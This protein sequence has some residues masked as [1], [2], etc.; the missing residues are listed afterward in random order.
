MRYV[1]QAAAAMVALLFPLSFEAH[2]QGVQG[3]SITNYQFVSEQ[4]W[5]Q[6]QSYVTYRADLVNTGVARDAVTATVSSSSPSI[7]TVPGQT[8]LHFSPVPANSRVT[9][10][11]TFTIL[12]D[13]TVPF[14]FSSLQWSFLAPYANAGPNQTV[15]IGATVTVNG[16]AST[17]PSG[18]GNLSY[19]WAFV[20]RP[21]GTATKLLGSDA[22]IAQFTVDV[23]GNYVLSLTVSNGVG[24]DTAFVTISTTNSPPVANAG[25][26]QTVGLGATVT[27]NGGGSSDVDG[28][29]LTYSWTLISRPAGSVATLTG[30]NTV[31]PTFVVDKAGAYVAQLI[32][33]DGKVNSA[34]ATVQITTINTPPVANAGPNQIVNVGSTVQLNGSAS[35]DVDGDSLTYH[36]SFNSRPDGS[37]AALSNATAV[38]PTFTADAP[39]TY[40]VQL[41]VNDGK[42][43][44]NPATVTITT[45]ALQPPTANAGSNQTVQHGATV[46]LNGSAT[47][48]QGLPLKLQWS[49]ITKPSGSAAVLSSTTIARPTFVA[50]LPGTYIADRKSV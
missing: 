20:S 31:S 28:D 37:A 34:P 30:A 21:P 39:G 49:L 44:S 4:R 9:S 12:V 29:A 43:D 46:S 22:V 18:V 6:T 16:S 11:N 2:G 26:N 8:N 36:W 19:K 10:S 1:C 15:G 7:Q 50:D 24:S 17:N 41:I 14:S 3:L 35:T 42:A 45:N 5:S 13:R 38:S 23:P 47:D 32:V 48:P 40:V 27:L 25:A 33:N